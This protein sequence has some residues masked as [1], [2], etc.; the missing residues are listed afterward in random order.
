MY[1]SYTKDKIAEIKTEIKRLNKAVKD[2]EDRYNSDPSYKSYGIQGVKETGN[3]R[4]E[5]LSFKYKMNKLI[6]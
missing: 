6:Y 5:Y 3:L 4:R 1:N 2:V